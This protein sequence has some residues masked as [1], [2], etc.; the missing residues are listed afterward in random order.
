MSK[1][2]KN[3]V[4]AHLE[5][6]WKPRTC[7]MCGEGLWNVQNSIYQ[8]SEYNEGAF[9]VGGPLIPVIPVTCE[10]CG[11][12]VLVNAILSGAIT[13]SPIKPKDGK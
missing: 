7:P 1:I 9:V 10:N 5:S 13:P 6:K 12:T 11:H 2:D 4:I 8:L 3:K